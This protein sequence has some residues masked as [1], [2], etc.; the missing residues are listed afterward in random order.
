M[1]PCGCL[2]HGSACKCITGHWFIRHFPAWFIAPSTNKAYEYITI[3]AEDRKNEALQRYLYP[4]SRNILRLQSYSSGAY[5]YLICRYLHLRDYY[6][7]HLTYLHYV[8]IWCLEPR[9][10]SWDLTRINCAKQ[11]SQ[12][13]S[14]AE[15]CHGVILPCLNL[16][17]FNT[18]WSRRP[19]GP[20]PEHW[21]P[22]LFSPDAVSVHPLWTPNHNLEIPHSI[23]NGQLEPWR[24]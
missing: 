2:F 1:R 16:R 19:T 4:L 8:F 5:L 17:R 9:I 15:R 7:P 11:I 21:E 14:A 10:Y 12:T 18:A 22:N 6:S 13:C 24:K 3:L 20:I 23:R